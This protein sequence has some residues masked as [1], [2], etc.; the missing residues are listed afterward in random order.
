M[1]DLESLFVEFDCTTIGS[2]LVSISNQIYRY[3]EML[4]NNPRD[5][6]AQIRI[7]SLKELEREIY[8]LYVQNG[9]NNDIDLYR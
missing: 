6:W 3:T 9:A 7:N 1:K 8:K 2:L 4:Y 5:T